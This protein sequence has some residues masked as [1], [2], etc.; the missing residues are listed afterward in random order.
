M[1]DPVAGHETLFAKPVPIHELLPLPPPRLLVGVELVG[2]IEAF[3]IFGAVEAGMGG[4]Y[5]VTE[6]MKGNG[7]ATAEI[8]GSPP[9][10]WDL[11]D[12]DRSG[13]SHR[14]DG[15]ADWSEDS[16]VNRRHASLIYHGGGRM[17]RCKS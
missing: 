10:L 15:N 1:S 14:G 4:V 6:R 13:E 5:I 11:V 7:D 16:M 17:T 3:G 8:L 2:L 12:G 9:D